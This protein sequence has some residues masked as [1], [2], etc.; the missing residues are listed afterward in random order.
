[1]LPLDQGEQLRRLQPV[2]DVALAHLSLDDLLPELLPRVRD[3]L[4]ADT[5]AVL[6]LDQQTDELVARAASGLEEEVERGVR[7]PL[8][9][10]FAGRVAAER[11]SVV[12]DD[13]DNAEIVNPILRERGVKSLVGTPLI[14]GE[15]VLGVVH[16]GSLRR[17][18]FTAEDV[19]LLE[20]AASRVAL[21]IQHAQA[22]DELLRLNELKSAFIGVAAHE[23]RTP[24]A[25]VY[26][27]AET[28]HDL[29]DQLPDLQ[30]NALLQALYVR[31]ARLR[32]L[33]EQLLDL[34]RLDTRSVKIEPK[35]T[36]V[37]PRVEEV[38]ETIVREREV[39]VELE[40]PADLE[41]VVDPL[42]LEHAVSN[43]VSNAI[44]YGE[45]PIR[46]EASA[47]DRHYR[48]IVE[49]HGRGVDPDFVPRLF[50]RFT[51][52][53]Q[54]LSGTSGA[55]LG[56]AIALAFAQAHGGTIT[57]EPAV[58]RGARFELVLPRTSVD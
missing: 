8:G 6:L 22:H 28:L 21:A 10:G 39:A 43:L 24:V 33:V 44:R 35:P 17:R 55:G 9:R 15:R 53:D 18:Q 57:Y 50:E 20:V 13:V 11:R 16:A 47:H 14:V 34:S 45:P 2:V 51:R 41:F 52:S 19:S 42:A 25:V 23:L 1:M 32:T 38:V 5:C 49:D 56:L 29:G 54:T 31:G 30:R 48:V 12:L 26:G 46:V 37:R 40:V 58:P 3:L 4:E 27:V 7:I 36:L